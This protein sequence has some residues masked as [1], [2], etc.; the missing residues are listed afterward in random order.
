MQYIIK[1]FKKEY[2]G[3]Y[4]KYLYSFGVY[5]YENYLYDVY[6]RKLSNK[7]YLIRLINIDESVYGNCIIKVIKNSVDNVIIKVYEPE[8]HWNIIVDSSGGE[9]GE[10]IEITI[11]YSGMWFCKVYL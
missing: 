10:E 8:I 7:V 6:V 11:G 9:S 2:Q 5:Y 4:G 3:E 1:H